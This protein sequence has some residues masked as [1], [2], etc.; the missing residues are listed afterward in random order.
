MTSATSEVEASVVRR[1]TDDG[2]VL[3]R[4]EA[5]HTRFRVTEHIGARFGEWT[6]LGFGSSK[7]PSGR[8]GEPY[9][10]VRCSC[11]GEHEVRSRHLRLGMSTR[12]HACRIQACRSTKSPHWRGGRFLSASRFGS[13]RG[14]A[15]NRDIP[16]EITLEEAENQWEKQVGKCAY[17]GTPLTNGDSD[18][19]IWTGNASLDRV[20]SSKG[21]TV[22]N[23][24]WVIK[25]VNTMKMDLSSDRFVE[26]CKLVAAGR[27]P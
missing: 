2:N 9:W 17:T 10:R 12:C 22:D 14:C 1:R 24:Q 3:S 21:Y 11:G 25:D 4:V 19:R 23:I 15:R 8:R 7:G 26:L 13:I 18:N 20:D 5:K 16:F 6:V 27:G